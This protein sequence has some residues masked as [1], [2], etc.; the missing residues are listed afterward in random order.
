MRQEVGAGKLLPG[1]LVSSG[2]VLLASA[3]ALRAA[4]VHLRGLTLAR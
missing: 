1:M 4:C 2:P 3:G